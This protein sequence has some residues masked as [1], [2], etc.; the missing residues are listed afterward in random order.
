MTEAE[1][2]DMKLKTKRIRERV[3]VITKRN[4][5]AKERV[6]TS[7]AKKRQVQLEH[8]DI[9]REAKEKVSFFFEKPSSMN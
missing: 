4:A 3:R 7:D 9:Q 5:S 1:W 2:D 6:L 8:R